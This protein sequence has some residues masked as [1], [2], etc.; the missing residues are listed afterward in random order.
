MDVAQWTPK[1]TGVADNGTLNSSEEFHY[2]LSLDDKLVT[3]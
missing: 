3:K 1:S 2:V